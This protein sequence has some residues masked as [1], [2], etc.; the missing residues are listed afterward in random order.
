M[1]LS[2][3]LF[4]CFLFRFISVHPTMSNV[5]YVVTNDDSEYDYLQVIDT[6]TLRRQ[7]VYAPIEADINFVSPYPTIDSRFVCK[8]TDFFVQSQMSWTPSM[9]L[10]AIVAGRNGFGEFRLFELAREIGSPLFFTFF[11]FE[12]YNRVNSSFL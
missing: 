5:V 7:R 3:S 9:S 10:V 8:D 1:H 2:E 11:P 6:I 4:L 12:F